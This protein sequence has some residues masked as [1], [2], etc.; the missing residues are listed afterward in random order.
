M[1]RAEIS[2]GNETNDQDVVGHD[3]V[4][5]FLEG[6]S[7]SLHSEAYRH[8]EQ[9]DRYDHHPRQLQS[10]KCIEDGLN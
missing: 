7:L 4:A 6:C 8:A 3:A 5:I 1:T 10:I 2:Y 9:E